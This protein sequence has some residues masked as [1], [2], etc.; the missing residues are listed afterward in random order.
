MMEFPDAFAVMSSASRAGT[1]A[2][3]SD[4]R[5]DANRLI[6]ALWL[7]GPN[8][9]GR[10]LKRSHARIHLSVL[11][12]RR[13]STTPMPTNRMTR[14]TRQ[15]ARVGEI[16]VKVRVGFGSWPPK[17]VKSFLK[18]GTMTTIITVTMMA[19]TETTITG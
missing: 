2:E 11:I 14:P 18:M 6:P 16:E 1:P 8:T 15:L 12:H 13:N 19:I 10:I 4:D 9:G 5:V 3:S 7:R 17:L